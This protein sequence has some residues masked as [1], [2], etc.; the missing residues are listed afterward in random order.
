MKRCPKCNR[1][2]ASD[3][4]TFCLEDGALLSAPYLPDEPATV[5]T[6]PSSGPPPT[7]VLPETRPGDRS[8]PPKKQP[9]SALPATI[10]SPAPDAGNQ[11]KPL[12]PLQIHNLVPPR[13]KLTWRYLAI[14]SLAL[15]IFSGAIGLYAIGKSQCP[16]LTLHCSPQSATG[17]YCG[18]IVGEA[19]HSTARFDSPISDALA[20]RSVVL[21]QAQALPSSITSVTWSASSG[22][23]NSQASQM[24]LDTTGLSG[25]RITVKATVT[26]TSWLCSDTVSTS[27]VVPSSTS[28]TK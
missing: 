21:L 11:A 6:I 13:R 12:A 22:L 19:P 25:Q 15:I 4:F 9:E 3:E 1:T 28:P 26:S 24:S 2:Y 10:A 20:S 5:P 14:A 23:I 18:L 17:T 7:A 8:A 16:N 27:F